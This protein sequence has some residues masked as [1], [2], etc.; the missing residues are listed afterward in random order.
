MT[1]ATLSRAGTI[2]FLGAVLLM[3]MSGC[4]ADRPSEAPSPT[5]ALPSPGGMAVIALAGDPDVLNPLIRRSAA[6]GMV[7]AE[8]LDTLTELDESLVAVPRIAHSWELAPDGLSMSYHLRPW[9]W[10][11]GQPL[12][13]RDVAFS[14]GL[15]KNPEIGA[16]SRGFY[17]DVTAAEAPDDSTLV[18]HFARRLPDP[19]A[20]TAHAIMPWHLLA[21]LEPSQVDRWPL[22]RAPLASGPFRLESWEPSHALVLERNSVYPG[23]AAL[24]DRVMFRVIPEPAARVLALEAGE[25]DFVSAVPPHSAP[26]LAGNP[27]IELKTTEGRRFYY[28]LWNCRDPR[29]ED[30][31]TRH[32]LSLALDRERMIRTLLQ[33]YA[34][35]AV[36]PIAR[37]LWNHADDL[38]PDPHDPQQARA[39]LAAAGWRPDPQDGIL[40]RDG[41]KLELE[42]LTRSGDP[43][44]RDGAVII[45]ENLEA[46]GVGV[47]FRS[48]ELA[49]GLELLGQGEFDV[50]FG[51]M[52]PNLY[53]D[54]SSAVH[55]AAV[56]EYNYGFYRNSVVDSLL[57][58]ALGETEP[59]SALPLWRQLQEVLKED[60]PAAYLFSPQR[61]DAVSRRI[62]DVRPHVLSPVNNLSEWWIAP[63]AR[64]YRTR[65][66]E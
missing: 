57:A 31:A 19:L 7:L 23:Q 2:L 18:Y 62:N 10:E 43:V 41:R 1:M 28:L 47:D 56:D 38:P 5:T 14:F 61:L 54:P 50:Y 32:A 25:V 22:N 49:A 11:D 26:R 8:I 45:R 42:I 55:S 33:G 66:G 17:G 3:G 9:R 6:G 34:D 21:D 53:G 40:R 59:R 64:K 48:L 58:A 15:F 4:G 16:R 20:R 36:S 13:A 35:P 44:R 63:E 37:M 29:L 65:D 27:Q 39:L 46:V 51:A 30:A 52:N 12:T 24:L 60:P